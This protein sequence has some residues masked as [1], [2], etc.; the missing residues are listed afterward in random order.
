[1]RR[2]QFA[3]FATVT[4]AV[5]LSGVMVWKAEATPLTGSV[6]PLVMSKGMSAAEKASCMFGTTRCAAGTKWMCV[7]GSNANGDTK[8]CKCRAC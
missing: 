3:C 6:E 8:K 7:K 2:M 5:L 1:M 4:A